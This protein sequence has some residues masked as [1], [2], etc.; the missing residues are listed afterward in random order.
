MLLGALVAA[1]VAVWSCMKYSADRLSYDA[2]RSTRIVDRHGELLYER[3]GTRGGYCR[4][5]A[6]ADVAEPVVLATLSSE[7]SH[8]RHHP[9]IDPTGVARALWLNA[10]E[11]RLAYGGSTIT[12]QLAKLLDPQPR[13]L[14]G[15]IAEAVDAT[16]L[17]R[18][19]NK[20]EILAQYLNRAYYGRQA[21]GIEAAAW[22]YFGKSAA[23][24]TL[25]EGVL[26]AIQ[27]RSP[28]AYD[29]ARHPERAMRRRAHVLHHMARRG[30]VSRA[31]AEAAAAEPIELVD[32][33][34]HRR[35][36]HLLD[37]LETRD[38]LSPGAGEQRLTIDIGLQEQLE[39]QC[40]MHLEGLAG[41]GATQAGVVVIDN[42]SG[43]VLAMV[44]SRRYGE[45]AVAGAVNVTT[46]VRPPGSTLKPF[47]YAVAIERGANPSTL[48]H[49]IPTHWR[50]YQ[51][52]S[53]RLYHHGAVP[54]RDALGSSL[55][56]PAVRTAGRVGT[57]QVA[58]LL[59]DAGMHAVDPER[60]HGLSL[61]LG[62]VSVPL[63]ELANG[64]ATLA[65]GG[66]YLPYRVRPMSPQPPA[67][68]VMTAETAY[69]ITDI[70]ADASARRREFGFETPLELPFPAAAKTGTSQAFGDNVVVGFTT[71][72]T[73]AVW[74][75]NFDGTPMRGLLA[76]EGAAPLWRDAMRSS[77]RGRPQRPF[78]PPPGVVATTV[79]SGAERLA[80]GSCPRQ[81]REYAAGSRRAAAPQP[82]LGGGVRITGP[83][84]GAVFVLD[85][86]LPAERQRVEL[87]AT[88]Q[89]AR[90]TTVRWLVDGVPIDEV[91]PPQTTFWTLTAGRHVLRAETP[92]ADS[93]FDEIEIEVEGEEP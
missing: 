56:I 22:R 85:P 86:L 46:S 81:R 65:R 67:R 45:K 49:D 23:E 2:L 19:L 61:A 16:R 9:G 30:W 69:L 75:G 82:P 76:M 73:V 58:Q 10:R 29:P 93:A 78:E 57:E 1:M 74:V 83:P 27:P 6:L 89:A 20:D 26:L 37:Y 39:R 66:R 54:I 80:D 31:E 35:A 41:R 36:P 84:D 28:R 5:V 88:V 71:E 48:V 90:S 72:V 42:A 8:F 50:G 4:P 91:V 33:S 14:R 3:R 13:T 11:G 59:H 21:Y 55:N 87:R 68:A 38:L 12:Q 60:R 47:V 7:D 62:G 79:C 51:P 18:T 70:L 64:Y 25:A 34:Q 24:L 40:R 63:I 44:G 43:D 17:E 15:K 53:L 77:M 32:P 52:R 92:G